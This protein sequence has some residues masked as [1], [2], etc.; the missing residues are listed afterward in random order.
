MI[1]TAIRTIRKRVSPFP[2]RTRLGFNHSNLR[3]VDMGGHF[4]EVLARNAVD[5]IP[6]LKGPDMK[7]K[8]GD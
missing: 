1:A 3:Y 4:L 5:E 6:P 2:T 8:W 7:T